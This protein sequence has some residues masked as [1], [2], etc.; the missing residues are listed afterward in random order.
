MQTYEQLLQDLKSGKF[1]PIYLFGGEETY[2]IDQLCAFFEH[3]IVPEADKDY[4]LSVIY[5]ADLPDKDIRSVIAEARSVSML[6]GRK[7]VILKEAQLVK[8]WDALSAYIEIP[9]PNTILVICYKY[10]SPDKRLKVFRD[11]DKQYVFFT[12]DKFRYDYQVS[13]WISDYIRSW[14]TNH[15]D[16]SVTFDE[17]IAVI[18][19]EYLGNDLTR[20]VQELDKLL[21]GCSAD[22]RVI[23][24][25]MVEKYVGISKDYNVFELQ[26]AL[27]EKDILK[28]NRIVNYFADSKDHP[29]QKELIVI[30]NFFANLMVYLYLPTN[31]PDAITASQLVGV[32]PY[33]MKDYRAASHKYTKGQVMRIIGYIKDIDARSKG[34]YNPS[35]KDGDLWKELVYKILH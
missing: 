3:N 34:F 15:K 11:L 19:A 14:N 6:G 20:I 12:A 28:A 8:K 23:N 1:S 24:S 29:I 4:N 33:F 13:K 2:Y 16:T 32:N 5:G 25:T 26:R 22:T 17:T 30:Y 7:V 21:K 31:V 9:Q 27:I 35:A 10:G 18:L